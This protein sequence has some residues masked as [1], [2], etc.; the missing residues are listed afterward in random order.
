MSDPI[1]WP[2]SYDY[3]TGYVANHPIDY[4]DVLITPPVIEPL[5]LEEIKKFRRFSINSLD[6][7]F[8]IWGSSAR[9]DFEEQTGLALLTQ[10]REFALDSIPVQSEIQLS[11]A[12]VQSI[13]S[14]KYDD[15]DGI[16]QTFDPSNYVLL[17]KRNGATGFE[18]Y[19][20]L[21]TVALVRSSTTTSA[22]P[23]IGSQP[24]ALR[25]RY[26]CGFGSAPGSL[27]ELIQYALF[28][29]VG[30]AHKYGESLQEIRGVNLTVPGVDT[31]MQHARTRRTIIPTR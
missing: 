13:V 6:T 14:I 24:K 19:P 17:P 4:S 7:L 9:Q 23:S 5:D 1:I 18:T 16:E 29:F 15:V 8:D 28:M 11:R 12:P 22:W 25:I 31:V 27:P 26:I 10:T 2:T 3:Q 20:R 30:T 21:S